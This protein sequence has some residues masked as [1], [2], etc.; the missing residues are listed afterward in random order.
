MCVTVDLVDIPFILSTRTLD[1]QICIKFSECKTLNQLKSLYTLQP[2]FIVAE[3]R[4]M[5][6]IYNVTFIPMH[7]KS[8][9]CV[10]KGEA[11]APVAVWYVIEHDIW[12]S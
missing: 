2:T 10:N 4:R 3:W 11:K 12:S 7:Q 9:V 6:T 1:S 5:Y 8:V